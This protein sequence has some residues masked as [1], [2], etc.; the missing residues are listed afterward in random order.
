[1]KCEHFRCH[2][3]NL[4]RVAQQQERSVSGYRAGMSS[5][6]ALFHHVAAA[7]SPS[8]S[9]SCGRLNMAICISMPVCCVPRECYHTRTCGIMLEGEQ[10]VGLGS[11][12]EDAL[13]LGLGE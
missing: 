2:L 7:C 1:M 9:P 11:K 8:P 13:R 12:L 5:I 3:G 4:M 10:A 6:P